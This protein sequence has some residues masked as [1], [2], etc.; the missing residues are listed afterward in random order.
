MTPPPT[1]KRILNY[2]P[3]QY[4]TYEDQAWGRGPREDDLYDGDLLDDYDLDAKDQ[5]RNPLTT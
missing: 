5:H 3:T 4:D 1:R 2:D